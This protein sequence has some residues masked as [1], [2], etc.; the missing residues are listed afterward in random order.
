M[1]LNPEARKATGS[2][3]ETDGIDRTRSE[4]PESDER[5]TEREWESGNTTED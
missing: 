1:G 2:R 3:Q 4:N 5:L